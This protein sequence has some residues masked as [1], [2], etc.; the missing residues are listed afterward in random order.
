MGPNKN[1]APF[2]YTNEKFHYSGFFELKDLIEELAIQA[3]QD[4]QST[5]YEYA[6]IGVTSHHLPKAAPLISKFYTILSQTG[7]P[8]DVFVVLGPDHREQG[9]T[10]I[11]TTYYPFVTPF[12]I[13]ETEKDIIDDLLKQDATIDNESFKGE[14]SIGVQTIFIKLFFPEARIVPLIFRVD[15]SEKNIADIA[16]TLS[17]HKDKITLIGSIDFSHYQPYEFAKTLDS[18]SQR[19]LSDF[20]FG[21][22]TTEYTCS[23]A[24]LKIAGKLAT[25]FGIT[26]IQILDIANSYDFD[27]KTENTTGYINAIFAEKSGEPAILMFVG[28]IMLDRGVEYMVK[29]YGEGDYSFPFLKIADY[30]EKADILFGNLESPISDRGKKVGSIYSFRARPEAIEGLEYAGFDIVS[31]ANNHIFDYGK[32]AVEDSFKRLREAGIDF[33]GGGFSEKEACSPIIK[34]IKGI[35]IGF[36]AFTNLGSLTWQA[37][38]DLSGICWLDEK[39]KERIKEAKENSDL[40]IV[41]LHSGEEYQSQ[42]TSEQRYFSHLAIDA[43]ADLVVGHHS[44]VVQLI[45]RYKQG[46]IAYSLG[47]FVFDQGFSEETMKG[48]LLE[49]LIKNAKIEKVIPREI[50]INKLFQPEIG[51]K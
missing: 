47:N 27:Q 30:L 6:Q 10:P 19:M 51:E 4:Y 9:H 36:L 5:N 11:S 48:L 41:S 40:V 38:E 14:H 25:L 43:G 35:K 20:N 49:V 37:K 39:I 21:S 45:E 12:G 31:V 46:Y 3:K 8:R 18:E 26:K 23:P 24:T 44:H 13:L 16:E 17:H 29:K 33:A 32:E 2:D 50:K 34:E 28:D 1:L 7:G 22:F 42:P 15:T